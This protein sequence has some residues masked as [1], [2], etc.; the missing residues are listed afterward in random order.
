MKYLND[1]RQSREDDQN[2]RS[3]EKIR[4]LEEYINL[5]GR[6]D[7]IRRVINEPREV[8]RQRFLE[9]ERQRLQILAAEQQRLLEEEKLKA[10]AAEILKPMTKK[11]AVGK[12]KPK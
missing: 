7:Q 5:Q 6:I 2:H 11:T 10:A 3:N 4:Q 1:I 12:K 9:I 8:F